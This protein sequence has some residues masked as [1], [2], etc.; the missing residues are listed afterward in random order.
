MA[1]FKKI[2]NIALRFDMIRNRVI[3]T[4]AGAIV[5][6][7]IFY[8]MKNSLLSSKS[9]D[10][11]SLMKPKYITKPFMNSPSSPVHDINLLG[12]WIFEFVN[13]HAVLWLIISWPVT[14]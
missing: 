9:I 1:K 12:C 7:M 4:D 3:S 6:K 14:R 2:I 10:N 8:E 5:G 11:R 13:S